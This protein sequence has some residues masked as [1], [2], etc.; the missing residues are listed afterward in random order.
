[1]FRVKSLG[2]FALI[3]FHRYEWLS[4]VSHFH[5]HVPIT[6]YYIQWGWHMG[7]ILGV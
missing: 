3:A 4:L 2:Y 1:M 5:I 7:K 6:V